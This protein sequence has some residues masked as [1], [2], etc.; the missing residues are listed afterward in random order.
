MGNLQDL[1]NASKITKKKTSTQPGIQARKHADENSPESSVEEKK[2]P[3]IIPR[4]RSF[5]PK[6]IENDDVDRDEDYST[7]LKKREE[8]I[9]KEDECLF[10]WGLLSDAQKVV[11]EE[12]AANCTDNKSVETSYFMV[13]EFAESIGVKYEHLR[14][15]LLRLKKK[16]ILIDGFKYRPLGRA[17]KV[18][19]NQDA[20]KQIT[21][22]IGKSRRKNTGRFI[23]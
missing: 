18:K 15:I 1:M 5:H 16:K 8:S 7:S 23:K 10:S 4:A 14:S 3:E 21:G 9:P 17:I 13:R 6:A 19:F 12:L 20:L 11:L 2:R 22:S